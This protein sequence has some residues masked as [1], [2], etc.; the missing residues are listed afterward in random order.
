MRILI[1]TLMLLVAAWLILCR[2]FPASSDRMSVDLGGAFDRSREAL[3][4]YG[5]FAVTVGLWLTEG[6][7]GIPSSVV[8]FLP[9]VIPAQAEVPRYI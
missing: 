1:T 5:V 9:V 2:L 7:H 3:L 4:F 6:L 8:G